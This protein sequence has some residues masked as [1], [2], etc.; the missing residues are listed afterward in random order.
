MRKTALGSSACGWN[1]PPI[2]RRE[3]LLAVVLMY[4]SIKNIL[5]II[6]PPSHEVLPVHQANPAKP[7]DLFGVPHR[8]ES[9][10]G[11]GG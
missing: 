2:Y 9:A 7:H 1:S 10:P 8:G 11:G 3:I 4:S 6:S 5:D